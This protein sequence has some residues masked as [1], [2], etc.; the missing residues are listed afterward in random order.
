[1]SAL[2]SSNHTALDVPLV[3]WG[4]G[5]LVLTAVAWG[6]ACRAATR[7]REVF[8]LSALLMV[9]GLA[10]AVL[11]LVGEVQL[12]ARRPRIASIP[13]TLE[14]RMLLWEELKFS[15]QACL[16]TGALLGLLPFC[17]G[18]ALLGQ[19]LVRLERYG[20]GSGLS[21]PWAPRA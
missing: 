18:V 4:G 15:E 13:A 3:V 17:A 9:L 8:L 10:V 16:A 7:A 1:M 20:G 5:A 21:Q 11:G 2:L 14:E 6:V 12:M 19:G